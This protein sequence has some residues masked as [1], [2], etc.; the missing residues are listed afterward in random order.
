M[1][2]TTPPRAADKARTG[3][4]ATR[5]TAFTPL[6]VQL[7]LSVAAPRFF[8]PMLDNPPSLLGIPLGVVVEAAT[9]VW[10][11]IGVVLVWDT[12][13]LLVRSFAFV[14]FTIPA[15]FAVILSPALILIA[16]NLS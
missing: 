15:T 12:Q 13:S 9:M 14:F 3:R 7:I 4:I 5:L 8:G 1:A 16:Q 6:G 2:L 11:L 10:M